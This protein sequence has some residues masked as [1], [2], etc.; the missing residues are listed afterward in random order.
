MALRVYTPT[1]SNTYNGSSRTFRGWLE[2][3]LTITDAN[4]AQVKVTRVGIQKVSSGATEIASNR[5]VTVR[6]SLGDSAQSTYT[7]TGKKEW[8][9][10]TS[11][12]DYAIAT[13]NVIY[14][15]ERGTTQVLNLYASLTGSWSGSASTSANIDMPI[16]ADFLITYDGVL[17]DVTN[18]PTPQEKQ[19]GIDITLSANIPVLSGYTFLGWSTTSGG[20][21]AYDV[22]G[23]FSADANTTLYAV[24]FK[25]PTF[26]NKIAFR[27]SDT[28]ATPTVDNTSEKG[29]AK[30]TYVSGYNCTMSAEVTFGDSVAI[31]TITADSIYAY[32]GATGCPSG[33]TTNVAIDIEVTDK[34]NNTYT[35]SLATFVSPSEV[36]IDIF[37]RTDG[38]IN[39]G[40]GAYADELFE[41]GDNAKLTVAKDVDFKGDV[42]F[43]GTS[44]MIKPGDTITDDWHG[45]SYLTTSKTNIFI[46]VPINKIITAESVTVSNVTLQTRQDGSYTHGSSASTSVPWNVEGAIITNSG[47]QVTLKRTTTTNAVNN[48]AIG[49]AMNY[50]MTFS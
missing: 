22:G 46:T 38:K 2:Y 21:K 35:Y 7:K 18:L 16:R 15:A 24:W 14:S 27:T 4:Y 31:P 39:I 50:T 6:F 43:D 3:E 44:I 34:A 17:A 8:N 37:K 32:S 19:T 1:W 40:I 47:V 23:T 41:S 45:A 11:Y 5:T 28:G 25:A 49:V 12:A 10:G 36:G 42:A 9:S 13:P 20:N 29:F 48:S 33:D 26:T 30:V